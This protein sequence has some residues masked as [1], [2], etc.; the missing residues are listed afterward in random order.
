MKENYMPKPD[1][2]TPR[3][4]HQDNGDDKDTVDAENEKWN[5]T[6]AVFEGFL[7]RDLRLATQNINM[8]MQA[9][10]APMSAKELKDQ[11]LHS[12]D[13]IERVLSAGVTAGTLTEAKGKYSLA[14]A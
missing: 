9:R 1:R 11:T 14:G 7:V 10:R 2:F 3:N 12:V 8:L 6:Q 13:C 4:N 5:P